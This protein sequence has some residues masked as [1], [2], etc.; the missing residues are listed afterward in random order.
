M[1]KHINVSAKSSE[2]VEELFIASASFGVPTAA[3]RLE[4]SLQHSVS[5]N[6]RIILPIRLLIFFS[7]FQ[8]S[9][10]CKTTVYPNQNR[11]V[12]NKGNWRPSCT[13]TT[14]NL[15]SSPNWV[16][17]LQMNKPPPK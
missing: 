7:L 1:N 12:N 11:A 10:R 8:T 3:E 5:N 14:L 13:N 2:G 16:S 9:S 4:E 15:P 17:P 6:P